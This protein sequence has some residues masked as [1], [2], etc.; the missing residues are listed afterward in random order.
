M[1][2]KQS[3]CQ[4]KIRLPQSTRLDPISISDL[5]F[6]CAH[7]NKIILA[8]VVWHKAVPKACDAFHLC[9]RW[10]MGGYDIRCSTLFSS[11]IF[12]YK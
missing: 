11:V 10:E 12:N 1:K 3:T 9:T 8:G 4:D 6:S 2:S 5:V 7:H